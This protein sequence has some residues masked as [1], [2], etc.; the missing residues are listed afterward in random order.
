MTPP[1]YVKDLAMSGQA[2][3]SLKLAQGDASSVIARDLRVSATSR[4]P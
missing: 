1:L 2:P 4:R 3:G